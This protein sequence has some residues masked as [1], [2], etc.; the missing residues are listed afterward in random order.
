MAA[1][2]FFFNFLTDKLWQTSPEN[3]KWI[4]S[5]QTQWFYIFGLTSLGKKMKSQTLPLLIGIIHV[6]SVLFLLCFRARLFIDALWSPAGKGLTSWLMTW[7]LIVNLSLSHWYPWTDKSRQKKNEESDFTA[8]NRDHSCHS[9]LVLL[10][11]RA[12]L[13]I[14]ALWSLAGKGLTSWLSL[15][16]LIVKLSLSHW[17]TGS[18]VVF[19]CIDSWSLPSFLLCTVLTHYYSSLRIYFNVLNFVLLW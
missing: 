10:C 1:Q 2:V 19:D 14:D 18:G 4:N 17:Y 16:C 8:P 3:Q 6:I 11:F 12:R 15:W 5:A 13:F 9:C 7:C